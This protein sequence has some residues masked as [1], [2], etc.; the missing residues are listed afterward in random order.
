MQLR[1]ERVTSIFKQ[2]IGDGRV[3]IQRSYSTDVLNEFS[4]GYLDWIHIDGN[5]DYEVVRSD[6]ELSFQKV[7]PG[8]L[9][10][11]DG[12]TDHRR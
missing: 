10:T 1:F 11:G 12:Y 8:G 9:I 2:E 7:K 6:L 5:H 4:D 3:V